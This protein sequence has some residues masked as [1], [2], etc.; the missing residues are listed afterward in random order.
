MGPDHL[1]LLD[2]DCSK[3]ETQSAVD[4]F[5]SLII[6][7]KICSFLLKLKL[8]ICTILDIIMYD[9]KSSKERQIIT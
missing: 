2:T 4:F 3:W 1:D 6:F 7:T 9:I 8:D 5:L